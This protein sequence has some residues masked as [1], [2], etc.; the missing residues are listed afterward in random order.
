MKTTAIKN[1]EDIKFVEFKNLKNPVIREKNMAMRYNTKKGEVIITCQ[2]CLRKQPRI[3]VFAGISYCKTCLLYRMKAFNV[4]K[5]IN[6][7]RSIGAL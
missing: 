2:C 6:D 1:I 7:I 5:I 3:F 4:W